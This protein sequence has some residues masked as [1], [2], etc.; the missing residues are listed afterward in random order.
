MKE[1]VDLLLQ[2]KDREETA[3]VLYR[4]A[5]EAAQEDIA[6]G[7]TTEE[8]SQAEARRLADRLWTES[9]EDVEM[10]REVGV[11]AL[12]KACQLLAQNWAKGCERVGVLRRMLED[13]RAAEEDVAR[14]GPD[15]G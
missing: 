2:V 12:V 8:T 9:E 15:G 7:L 6:A 14:E 13:L 4:A 5:E 11:R 1:C 3:A 10:A